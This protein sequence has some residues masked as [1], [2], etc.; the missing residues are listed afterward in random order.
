MPELILSKT[1]NLN[2]TPKYNLEGKVYLTTEG[3]LK[4]TTGANIQ[5]K[6]N[7]WIEYPITEVAT[8]KST[9]NGYI[10]SD[11]VACAPYMLVVRYEEQGV[12]YIGRRW[13]SEMEED[14]L[15]NGMTNDVLLNE[16]TTVRI[17]FQD[18]QGNAMSNWNVEIE[19]ERLRTDKNGELIFETGVNTSLCCNVWERYNNKKYQVKEI[20]NNITNETTSEK[21]IMVEKDMNITVVVE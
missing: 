8:T 11:L 1:I 3:V 2:Q 14:S 4:V 10:V 5:V 20:I 7:T 9:E 16:L 12:K 17:K 19:G 15:D 13:V 18:T 6:M 21:Y